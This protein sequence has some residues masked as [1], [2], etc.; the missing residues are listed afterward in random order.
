M[1]SAKLWVL[2]HFIEIA[3]LKS[4]VFYLLLVQELPS[5]AVHKCL[6]EPVFV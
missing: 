3:F 2:F 6:T 4:D 1:F 5:N